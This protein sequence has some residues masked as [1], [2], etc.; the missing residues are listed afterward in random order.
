MR[1]SSLFGAVLGAFLILLVVGLSQ[2]VAQHHQTADTPYIV[3]NEALRSGIQSCKGNEYE[4][5]S[6]FFKRALEIRPESRVACQK[7]DKT[8]SIIQSRAAD[9]ACTAPKPQKNPEDY[10]ANE[11]EDPC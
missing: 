5:A 9:E 2:T 3:Y 6:L 1:L 10:P 8:N 4:K 11:D 7:Y